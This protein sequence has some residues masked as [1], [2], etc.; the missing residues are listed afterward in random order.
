MFLLSGERLPVDK[1]NKMEV[2]CGG[3]HIGVIFA[4]S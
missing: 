1:K 3:S 4:M 2:E